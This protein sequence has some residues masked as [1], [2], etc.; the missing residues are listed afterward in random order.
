MSRHFS[1]LIS[2]F[3]FSSSSWNSG[4]W[5]GVRK[6]GQ[7]VW[8]GDRE[9]VQAD[10]TAKTTD[11]NNVMLIGIEKEDEDWGMNMTLVSGFER[12]SMA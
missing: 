6:I 8:V 1:L 5:T 3:S 12:R 11:P 10:I 7:G 4:P 2:L 9:Q